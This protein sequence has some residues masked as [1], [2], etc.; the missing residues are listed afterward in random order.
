MRDAVALNGHRGVSK[1]DRVDAG[2]PEIGPS[3]PHNHRDEVDGYLVQQPE[4]EAL[5][6]NRSRGHADGPF[7]GDLLAA[8]ERSNYA[9]GDEGVRRARMRVYPFRR[10]V[11]GHDDDGHVNDADG[12]PVEIAAI[13]VWQ[14]ADTAKSTY[15]VQNY[16][17]FVTV[18][19]ES[20]LRHVATTHP[21]DDS[22]DA[23]TSLRGSTDVVAAQLALEV[24][25]RVS[26][27]G[28][29]VVE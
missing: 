18:Q 16:L 25:T 10:H 27:A 19:A 8:G 3:F 11:V 24:S 17:D 6:G 4:L 14:I 9:V 15:A 12:S 7:P 21:Y 13:V 22:T 5:S 29:E 23:G 20:A 28:V 2:R 1:D 26:I